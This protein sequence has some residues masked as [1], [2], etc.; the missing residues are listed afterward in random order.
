MKAYSSIGTMDYAL[1]MKS[2]KGIDYFD[3]P[4][5]LPAQKE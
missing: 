1:H 5:F 2:K 4:I 3:L